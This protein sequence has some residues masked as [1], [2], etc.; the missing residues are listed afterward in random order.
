MH[1]FAKATNKSQC[2]RRGLLRVLYVDISDVSSQ[3]Y[4]YTYS[5]KRKNRFPETLLQASNFITTP[6]QV[7]ERMNVQTTKTDEIPPIF[8]PIL[9]QKFQ[10]SRSSVALCSV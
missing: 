6:N 3:N 9:Q 2:T 10:D 8:G 1:N 4:N 5:R 7:N